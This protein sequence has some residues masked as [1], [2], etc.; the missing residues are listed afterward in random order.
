M[1]ET[2][3]PVVENS[4]MDCQSLRTAH[5]GIAMIIV[6]TLS[7][8]VTMA[9]AADNAKRSE[10]FCR[11][12]PEIVPQFS[13]ATP[14]LNFSFSRSG[15]LAASN[16]QGLADIWD[17][18]SHTLIRTLTIPEL[19]DDP[20]AST[21]A[22]SPD[23][24]VLAHADMVGSVQLWD[25]TTGWLDKT[26]P[27]PVGG[28]AWIAWSPNSKL[29]A[30]GGSVVRLWDAVAGKILRTFPASGDLAFS[31]D[32]KLLATV[33]DGKAQLFDVATGKLIRMFSDKSGVLFPVAISADKTL[34]ATG[35]EDSDWHPGIVAGLEDETAHQLKVKV[36]SVK[37][38]KLV[39]MFP[40]HY[41]SD[42]GTRTLSFGQDNRTI[43][44][45]GKAYCAIWDIRTGRRKRVFA[46]TGFLS[47]YG[48]LLATGYGNAD[49]LVLLSSSTGKPVFR[50]LPPPLPMRGAAFSPDG[51][52]L[53]IGGERVGGCG[54]WLWDMEKGI[55]SRAL[56]APQS[57]IHDVRFLPHGRVMSNGYNAATV[58]STAT[59]KPI[60]SRKG[61]T[62]KSASGP[63]QQWS[64]LS[65]DASIM[66]SESGGAF[67]QSFQVWDVGTKKLLRTISVGY[68]TVHGS[69][70]SPDEHYFATRVGLNP[71]R[72]QVF[73]LTNGQ[74]VSQLE[75][76]DSQYA[77]ALVFSPD[78]KTIAGVLDSGIALWDRDSGKELL[79]IPA[80]KGLTFKSPYPDGWE[81]GKAASLAFARDGKTVAAGLAGEVRVYDAASGNEL[82]RLQAGND[83]FKC[84]AFSPDGARLAAGNEAGQVCL[85]DVKTRQLLITLV[86][87]PTLYKGNV[88]SD[89]YAWI[90]DGF[91]DWS[92]G[93][94]RLLRWNRNGQIL[95]VSALTADLLRHN[96]L[97]TKK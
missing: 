26:L 22:L 52:L 23:G 79:R 12:A 21:I 41:S 80:A 35:G 42:G 67:G 9:L 77:S 83:V 34:L 30:A 62:E 7:G 40:S 75:G 85:W 39:H 2:P 19:S 31:S 28:P 32:G 91:Y 76:D 5:L 88:S 16:G 73:D 89:W 20:N 33:G 84:V 90:P 13:H 56:R 50:A 51:Q 38:G 93:A 86:A 66:A 65:P 95:P 1:M 49:S 11:E 46:E 6:T 92:R 59:G 68:G 47:P 29:V 24:R 74:E 44:S 63:G 70:F 10:V 60:M 61:P 57:G 81:K 53:A 78:G 72:T 17:T 36:W 82:G 87:L 25:V 18:S 54:L 45:S 69:A 94:E 37:T 96:L 43:L 14:L 97:K 64:R 3:T 71:G 4:T 27:E 58:W 55:L 8:V 48:K 15:R